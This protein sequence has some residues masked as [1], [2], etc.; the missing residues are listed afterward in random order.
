[1]FCVYFLFIFQTT[2][3]TYSHI[4]VV[5]IQQLCVGIMTEKKQED[6]TFVY[7]HVYQVPSIILQ[8]KCI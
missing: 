7:V 1:M 3:P 5:A 8:N 2:V 6:V 4:A